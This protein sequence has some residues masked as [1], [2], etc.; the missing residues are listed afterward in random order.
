M[1]TSSQTQTHGTGRDPNIQGATATENQK[2]PTIGRRRQSVCVHCGKE[3]RRV[4]ERNR[5]VREKHERQR[6]CPFCDFMW[7][8]PDIIKAHIMANHAK[9]I[10]AEMRDQLVA[11]RGRKATRF[12]DEYSHWHGLDSIWE[13][14]CDKLP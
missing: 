1:I 5:H 14:R 2:K 4:Q 9:S 10:T 13:Q 6:Q 11:L 3:F 7:A 12:L 8:R